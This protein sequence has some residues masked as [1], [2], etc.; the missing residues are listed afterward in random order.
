M[1]LF[2]R[3][4]LGR[5]AAQVVHV[6]V[7]VLQTALLVCVDLEALAAARGADRQRL[8]VQVYGELRRRVAVDRRED[9][10]EELPLTVIGSSPLLRALLRKMSAKLDTTTRN[11]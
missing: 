11:P 9:R 10:R 3:F 5:D 2:E 1:R 4:D 7:A 8:V 6:V